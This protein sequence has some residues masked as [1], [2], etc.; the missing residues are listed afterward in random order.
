MIM[1]FSNNQMDDLYVKCLDPAEV[2][3]FDCAAKVFYKHTGILK[4]WSNFFLMC[5]IT[6]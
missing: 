5:Q 2:G 1:R 6:P 3:P 4:I